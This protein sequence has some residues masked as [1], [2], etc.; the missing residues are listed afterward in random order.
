VSGKQG[1]AG[2]SSE[3]Y[4]FPADPALR[5]VAQAMEHTGS[6]SFVVDDSWRIVYVTEATRWT[7]G[8]HVER[9]EFAIGCHFFGPEMLAASTAWRFGPNT[10][11][12]VGLVLEAVGRWVIE[13]APGGLAEVREALD[14]AVR[15]ALERL[16][17]VQEAA[18]WL[19]GEGAGLDRPV[20]APIAVLRVRRRDGSLAGSVLITQPGLS[21]EALSYVTMVD[22]SHATLMHRVAK[23]ARRPAAIMFGDLERSSALG[24]RM[25]TGTYFSLGRRLVGAADRC[26]IEHGGL[27]GRHVG[28]GIAAFFLDEAAGS[29]SAAARQCIASARRLRA[30]LPEIAVASGLD[31]G[32]LSLRFGLH[33]G[34]T[35]Y[36]GSITTPGRS[37]VTALG[38][39]VNEGARIE[40]CATDGRILAS[41]D[42]VERLNVADGEALEI[43]PAR[44]TYTPLHELPGATDKARRDAPAIPVCEL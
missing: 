19:I 23:A 25:S 14:A 4:P 21:M 40:A 26:V 30:E 16:R 15:P 24:R 18:T 33:W 8:G 29:E 20:A 31:A 10:P 2:A 27:V 17:P 7:Y 12:R 11:E 34:A 43:D 44:I 41:K 28:D 13:D 38:D 32:E 36:V 22:P 35:L 9:A 5:E 6:W 37:E 1:E 39:E 42:L 3:R